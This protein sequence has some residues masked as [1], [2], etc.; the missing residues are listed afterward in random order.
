MTLLRH[1]NSSDDTPLWAYTDEG[2]CT[3]D[4]TVITT[5]GG[6]FEQGHEDMLTVD[7]FSF[8][9]DLFLH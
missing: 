1:Y 7:F 8:D 3:E 9:E 6:G 5:S 4:S 2:W